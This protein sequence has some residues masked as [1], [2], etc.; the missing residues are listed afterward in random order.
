[1]A[2]QQNTC[3][4]ESIVQSACG[5]FQSHQDKEEIKLSDGSLLKNPLFAKNV[6]LTQPAQQ[7]SLG[8]GG[9]GGGY[10]AGQ[11]SLLKS[12]DNIIE[13]EMDAE[14]ILKKSSAVKKWSKRS[15]KNFSSG[16]NLS[17][18]LSKLYPEEPVYANFKMIPA[19][20]PGDL[21]DEKSKT[22]VYTD[23][24]IQSIAKSIG[25]K[26]LN[27]LKERHIKYMTEAFAGQPV[28]TG[29]VSTI[30]PEPVKPKLSD[31]M[32]S[33]DR[34]KRLFDYAQ[35]KMKEMI[36]R[37]RKES[38]LTE[39]ERNLIRRI[40]SVKLGTAKKAADMV[41]C[42][43]ETPN[44]FYFPPTHSVS[45]CENALRLSDANLVMIL[46]HEIGHAIDPCQSGC[47][48]YKA[49]KKMMEEYLSSEERSSIDNLLVDG[50][51]IRDIIKT[52][53]SEK[54]DYALDV[55]GSNNQTL[56]MIDH[57]VYTLDNK[58]IPEKDYPFNKLKSCLITQEGF[59]DIND[60]D[61]EAEVRKHESYMARK[62]TQV[63]RADKENL[64][65]NLMKLKNCFGLSEKSSEMPEVMSDVGGSYVLSSYLKDN[66]PK[67][68]ADAIGSVGMFIEGSCARAPLPVGI[69]ILKERH[70]DSVRRL[71]SA[72]LNFPGVARHFSVCKDQ[73][74]S[75]KCFG[76]FQNMETVKSSSSST[77]QP[78][79]AQQ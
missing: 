56:S 22:K 51:S 19:T 69:E 16:P 9:Y 78:A 7:Y 66:P 34:Q 38:S 28:Y 53:K 14:A 61:I 31:R 43:K 3:S 71:K 12:M 72:I 29:S 68:E 32:I 44:A 73:K 6:D 65:K 57:K 62:G 13:L 26:S 8:Y 76:Q 18:F 15:L 64:K 52:V 25:A 24:E 17:A 41:S 74:V 55:H 48:H 63:T 20:G 58:A 59:D 27:E 11:D 5:F 45:L 1:M 4:T 46:G 36:I 50:K 77:S 79:E 67:S 54:T 21:K 33:E 42:A 30:N 70:P 40:E 49:D 75:N 2:S 23:E 35:E 10:G 37:G 47:D 60:K 39:E